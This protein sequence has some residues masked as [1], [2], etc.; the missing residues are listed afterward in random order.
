MSKFSW[1]L[2]TNLVSF[3]SSKHSS[4][5][6]FTAFFTTDLKISSIYCND[7]FIVFSNLFTDF[8]TLSAFDS[9][10][11]V[12]VKFDTA[13]LQRDEIW[14]STDDSAKSLEMLNWEWDISQS[15]VED[16]R[17]SSC[18]AEFC[19]ISCN[20]S[21]TD[22]ALSSEASFSQVSRSNFYQTTTV[23]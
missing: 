3:R 21:S 10:V 7:Y 16:V 9:F 17:I 13:H 12:L 15:I 1:L 14:E 23:K 4:S 20:N 5:N 22:A 11:W 6:I 18:S 8:V 19:E 2:T